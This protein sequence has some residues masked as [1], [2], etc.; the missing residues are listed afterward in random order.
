MPRSQKPEQPLLASILLAAIEPNQWTDVKAFLESNASLTGALTAA[1]THCNRHA[2]DY[3]AVMTTKAATAN[4]LS[5]HDAK[6]RALIDDCL[7]QF[8]DIQKEIRRQQARSERLRVSSCRTM[9]D[10]WEVLRRVEATL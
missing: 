1:L 6:Y 10:T 3:T 5:R 8:K 9:D 4:G 7:R 2:E